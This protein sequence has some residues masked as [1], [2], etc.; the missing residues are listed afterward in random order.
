MR[1]PPA[2]TIG[3]EAARKQLGLARWQ[4]RLAI[5][6]GLLT[7]DPARCFQAADIA[8]IAT[9]P[10]EFEQG[11]RDQERLVAWQAAALLGLSIGRFRETV[12]AGLFSVIET[13]PYR[14][15]QTYYFRRG[16]LESG[17]PALAQWLKE[18]A[19]IHVPPGSRA[20][21][22]RAARRTALTQTARA[23][24][25]QFIAE[26]EALSGTPPAERALATLCFWLNLL[27]G[28]RGLLAGR[29]ARSRRPQVVARYR[30][31]AEVLSPL[32]D[33]A[34]EALVLTGP[35]A[36]RIQIGGRSVKV[37]Y[38]PACAAD[39]AQTSPGVLAP[40]GCPDCLVDLSSCYLRLEAIL[41]A[42]T[43]AYNGARVFALP[44]ADAA[45]LNSSGRLDPRP[46]ISASP[47][48]IHNLTSA[49]TMIPAGLSVRPTWISQVTWEA[50][51]RGQRKVALESE[52]QARAA[53]YAA[54]QA[55]GEELPDWLAGLPH[56]AG[57]WL[58][59]SAPL[60][61]DRARAVP[62]REVARQ[63]TAAIERLA[64]FAA[65]AIVIPD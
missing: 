22:A 40:P 15:G 36:V 48:L 32:R 59:I 11:L 57:P 41:S 13:K 28:H 64:G 62:A 34:L 29:A 58:P 23:E 25:S 61:V 50:M 63:L 47:F 12:A 39:L 10:L 3:P 14:W 65:P 5:A 45:R 6:G 7:P 2:G 30:D 16:D 1:K 44:L 18:R 31:Q 54:G 8:A 20:A 26:R 60:G 52:V 17:R 46:V 43:Q 42:G 24:R 51:D 9:D 4:L 56:D 33:A 49:F 35:P 38:C 53:R 19:P 27:E 37:L 55:P 21:L